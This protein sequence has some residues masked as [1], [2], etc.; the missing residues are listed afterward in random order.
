MTVPNRLRLLLL[1]AAVALLLPA[2]ASAAATTATCAAA[3]PLATEVPAPPFLTLAPVPVAAPAAGGLAAEVEVLTSPALLSP[4]A[5]RAA[6]K[7]PFLCCNCECCFDLGADAEGS[8]ARA[9]AA[10][11]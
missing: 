1:L 2:A 11:V 7:P 6:C 4:A 10:A 8:P 9:T 5:P 3:V